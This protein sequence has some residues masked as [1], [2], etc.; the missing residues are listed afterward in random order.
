MNEFFEV[1]WVNATYIEDDVTQTKL[2]KQKPAE[3]TTVA[4]PCIAW[5]T[6]SPNL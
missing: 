5:S 6:F 3:F 4:S 1:P 2:A